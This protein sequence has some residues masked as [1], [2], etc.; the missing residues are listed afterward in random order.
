M[1]RKNAEVSRWEDWV[2]WGWVGDAG[3]HL[4]LIAHKTQGQACSKARWLSR[5]SNMSEDVPQLVGS[6]TRMNKT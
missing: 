1:P 4:T 2:Y 5:L 6:L 3:W